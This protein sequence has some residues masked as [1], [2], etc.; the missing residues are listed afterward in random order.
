[1]KEFFKRHPD[2]LLGLLALV[3]AAI[4]AGAAAW[5][6]IIVIGNLNKAV[7]PDDSAEIQAA[8]FDLETARSLDL[9]GLVD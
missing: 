6:I 5:S 3:F 2:L 8:T 4:L 7:R 1:M 9:K